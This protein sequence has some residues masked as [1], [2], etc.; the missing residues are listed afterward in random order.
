MNHLIEVAGLLAHSSDVVD[1]GQL[2]AAILHDTIEDTDTTAEELTARFGADVASLVLEVTD[3]EHLSKHARKELQIKSAPKKS[4]RAKAI[5][6][7]D[8]ISNLRSILSSP[9]WDWSV[10]RKREYF[11]WA[12][13]VV[14]A[15]GPVNPMLRA[16]FDRVYALFSGDVSSTAF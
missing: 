14:D 1:V 7:A 10:D 8:K 4:D 16:E 13:A 15:C 9:P 5:K 3:D 6:V 12:K 2:T 11:D